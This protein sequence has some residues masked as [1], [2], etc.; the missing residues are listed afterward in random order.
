MNFEAKS[1]SKSKVKPVQ[2]RVEGSDF[3][4]SVYFG[5]S[6]EYNTHEFPNVGMDRAKV[7]PLYAID[8]SKIKD[9]L[10]PLVELFQYLWRVQEKKPY[11]GP[12]DQRS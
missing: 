7:K 9:L 1:F 8:V 11:R 12:I 3:K 6:G 2:N 5:I 4:G 10:T